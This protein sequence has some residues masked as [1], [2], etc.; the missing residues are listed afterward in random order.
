MFFLILFLEA[1]FEAL[2]KHTN[3]DE[4][5]LSCLREPIGDTKY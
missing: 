3:L 2:S 4:G 1:L 5:D